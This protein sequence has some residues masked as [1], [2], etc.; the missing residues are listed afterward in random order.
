MQDHDRAVCQTRRVLEQADEINRL[1]KELEEKQKAVL[2]YSE[3]C[4]QLHDEREQV[5]SERNKVERQYKDAVYDG[6]GIMGERDTLKQR[7]DE[8]KAAL[9]NHNTMCG[10]ECTPVKHIQLVYADLG[11]ATNKIRD[12]AR[13]IEIGLKAQRELNEKLFEAT[14]AR[15]TAGK[16]LVCA[17]ETARDLQ[18]KLNI[19]GT[20]LGRLSSPSWPI[21]CRP[22][23]EQAAT[24]EEAATIAVDNVAAMC[25]IAGEAYQK[26]EPRLNLITRPDKEH[27]PRRLMG[28]KVP[29]HSPCD[30]GDFNLDTPKCSHPGCSPARCTNQHCICNSPGCSGGCRT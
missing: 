7:L 4:L 18:G 17:V 9:L 16:E 28:E 22:E 8:I 30:R 20:A 10:P 24:V 1:K 25:R 13:I 14:S 21:E 2:A 29:L 15:N 11:E 3:R 27:C 23:V 19:A 6:L 26:I 12:Q 5:K